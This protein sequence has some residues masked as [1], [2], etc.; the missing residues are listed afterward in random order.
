MKI[1]LVDDHQIIKE[2]VEESTGGN[3]KFG[4]SAAGYLPLDIFQFFQTVLELRIR[5]T[6]D[7]AD[8]EPS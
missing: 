4:L 2:V 5:T 3:L 8:R 7:A 1:L 6:G